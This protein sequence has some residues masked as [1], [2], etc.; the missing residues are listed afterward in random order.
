MNS[1][2][3]IVTIVSANYLAYARALSESLSQAAPGW[4]LRVLIVDRKTPEIQRLVDSTHLDC[5]FACDLGIPNVDRIFYVYDVVELNTALKPTFL[6]QTFSLGYEY[7]LYLDPDISV[8]APLDPIVNAFSSA[9]ILLT[10]HADVPVMDGLRPSD[11]DFLRTGSYNLG[12]IGLKSS[13]TVKSFLL[14]WESRCLGL[15]F[16]DPTFGIFV[17][18]KWVDLVPSYFPSCGIL[19]HQGCNV[20]YWNIHARHL[21]PGPNGSCLV[22]GQKLIFFHFSGVVPHDPHIFSK[23]QNRTSIISSSLLGQLVQDY[24]ERL[25]KCDYDLYSKIPYTYGCLDNGQPINSV[26]RRALHAVPFF[27]E[28][29]FCARSK[30]QTRIK[31]ASLTES[32]RSSFSVK[33]NSLSFNPGDYRLQIIH[34]LLRLSVKFFGIGRIL[35]LF[36]YLSLLTREFYLASVLLKEPLDLTHKL[37]R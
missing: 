14:W 22:N 21:D 31:S 15:G 11:V 29:P 27:Q 37:R 1:P 19:R 26:M 32:T 30:F 28:D 4:D 35:A 34:S 3:C 10:P 16:N 20:A 23:H 24:C 5:V 2:R 25:I 18:Q 12:F 33:S 17:D 6:S 8:Y 7:V 13:D 36:R 9:D